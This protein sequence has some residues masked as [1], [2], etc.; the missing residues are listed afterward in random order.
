MRIVCFANNWIG[1]R[2]IEFLA[3]QPDE[4]VA[5][6]L[7]P[8]ATRTH[9]DDIRSAVGLA[10]EFVFDGSRL[11]DP[12]VVEAIAGL[13]PDLGVSVLFNFLLR[14]PLL[15][16]FP[17]GVI[18]LHPG[19]LPFNR[20]QYPNVWSIVD[21]TPAGVTLHYIDEG[22]DTGDIIAQQ[23][24][25]VDPAD[26]GETLYRKLERTSV[27]LFKETWPLIRSGAPPRHPQ[28]GDGTS[29]RTADVDRIDRIDLDRTYTARALI[30]ILRARTFPPHDGAYFEVD[31]RRYRLRVELHE[32]STPDDGHDIRGV[33]DA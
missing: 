3:A 25:D 18:N 21:R 8:P 14:K 29:H 5:V 28:T 11:R 6:V 2:V 15:D 16:V 23:R 20:G 19:Y 32:R 1:W 30:D 22:V 4:I 31:G 10:D 12:E 33:R 26:T 17:A 7:H 24:V 9:G 13:K 27:E